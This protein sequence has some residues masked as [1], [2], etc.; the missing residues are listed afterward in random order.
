[1][2]STYAWSYNEEARPDVRKAAAAPLD[3]P[4]LEKT[5][6]T[7]SLKRKFPQPH[8]AESMTA[9]KRFRSDIACRLF[10]GN[11]SS[12]TGEKELEQYF[13]AFGEVAEVK[14]IRDQ[15]TNQ[16]K[17]FAFV[18]FQEA[19]SGRSRVLLVSLA[20]LCIHLLVSLL[21]CSNRS[22]ILVDGQLCG[23][24]KIR[25]VVCFSLTCCNTMIFSS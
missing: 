24:N 18:E 10:V 14:V 12:R 2:A 15:V 23:E 17:G 9:G 11:L 4:G 25:A 1:M 8:D 22:K 13:S 20:V 3:V 19:A 21:S 6:E 5:E 16:S 7:E